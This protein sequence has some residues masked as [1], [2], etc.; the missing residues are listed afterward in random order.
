MSGHNRRRNRVVIE[1]A[2]GGHQRGT[3]PIGRPARSGAREGAVALSVI[4]A[5]ALATFLALFLTSRPYNP[6]N[7]TLAP[8]QTAPAG[9]LAMEPSLKPSPTISPSPQK[10]VAAGAT[11]TP[12]VALENAAV[13]DDAG[14]QSQIDR[15]LTSDPAL[16]KLDVSTLVE[17]GRVTIVGSVRSAD[18]KQRIEK[19]LGSIKGVVSI[20][21][22]LVITEATP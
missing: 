7:S 15:T 1:T 11:P 4:G 17:S 3:R 9:S 20:D 6:M 14:I 12:A 22:Q 18:L 21:N 8:G 13:S 19:A 2:R 5:A 10:N 16:S